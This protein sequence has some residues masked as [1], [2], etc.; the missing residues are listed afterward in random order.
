[1]LVDENDVVECLEAS[2]GV[3]HTDALAEMLF[4]GMF[5]SEPCLECA[6]QDI[7]NERAFARAGDAGHDG[8]RA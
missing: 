8:Q 7:V 3:E 5:A 1:L 2:D 4:G 6:V